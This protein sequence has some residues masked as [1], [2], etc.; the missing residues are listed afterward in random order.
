[1]SIPSK[2]TEVTVNGTAQN[3]EIAKN[4]HI[5]FVNP[6]EGLDDEAGTVIDEY[7]LYR[8]TD[9]QTC[10]YSTI[11]LFKNTMQDMF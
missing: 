6:D 2:S 8:N 10:K 4:S 7:V 5:Y 9:N 11:V 1:M 3:A